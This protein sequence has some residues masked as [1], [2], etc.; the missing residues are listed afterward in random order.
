M[1]SESTFKGWQF[2]CV[3]LVTFPP[4]K[5]FEA[6]LRSYIQQA[7]NQHEGRVDV[8]AKYCL[9]RLAY[10]SK[11][12][13]RGKPPSAAEI[14]TA[15]VCYATAEIF[16][17]VAHLLF[18]MLRSIPLSSARLWTLFSGYRS[19]TTLIRR[20]PSSSPSS[21]T[22]SSLLVVPNRRASSAFLAMETS[23]RISSFA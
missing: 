11:K 10:I 13:P 5:N 17:Y 2:L 16:V 21:Q 7:T 1:H 20:C 3:L 14:E 18:R 23:S 15:S 6:Y 8:M 19:A 4:S 12:G 9:R 22:A